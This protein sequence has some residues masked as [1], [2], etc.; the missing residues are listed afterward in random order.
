MARFDVYRR[1][2][3]AGYLLDCQADL[4][5]ALNTRFVV[6][7]LPRDAAPVPAMR[8]NPMLTIAGEPHVMVTQF[9]AAV[10]LAELGDRVD[11]QAGET[12]RIV[13]AL[14]LLIAGV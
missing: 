6:P 14:D 10:T 11:T 1:R 4:L 5:S 3:R 9:A 12:D 7:L 8:L 13:G 2:G